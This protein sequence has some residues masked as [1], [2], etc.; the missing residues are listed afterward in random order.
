M[1]VKFVGNEYQVFNKE[2][3]SDIQ[4]KIILFLGDKNSRTIIGFKKISRIEKL[5]VVKS[6]LIY[7]YDYTKEQLFTAIVSL[8]LM[9]LLVLGDDVGDMRYAPMI[10]HKHDNY[11]Q[12]VGAIIYAIVLSERFIFNK[13]LLKEEFREFKNI[14]WEHNLEKD[15]R[16]QL[17]YDH[18]INK[19]F[20]KEKVF[21]LKHIQLTERVK[22]ISGVEVY[23]D[24]DRNRALEEIKDSIDQNN[25]IID[26]I[27][28]SVE[29]NNKIADEIERIKNDV[30]RNL[31]RN[32]EIIT[33]FVAVITLII[34]NVSFLPQISENSLLG[35]VSLVLIINGALVTGVSTLVLV[36]ARVLNIEPEKKSE[37]G[38]ADKKP[39]W[40]KALIFVCA[41]L[42]L[43][44]IALS[45]VDTFCGKDE[46]GNQ[47]TEESNT[48]NDTI[49][50][51]PQNVESSSPAEVSDSVD[52][53]E[54]EL[55]KELEVT[56]IAE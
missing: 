13:Q 39:R 31:L 53:V 45:V 44:G 5:A 14:D 15:L 32:I 50:V 11:V 19:Y 17:S 4:K 22:G 27:Q 47:V 40:K 49:L 41:G 23:I 34:G 46:R 35:A 20:D 8:C 54:E 37:Q 28:T 30:Q 42:L 12:Y 6:E 33:I 38:Q 7:E 24:L 3:L 36:L 16:N 51:M 29:Q 48:N 55:E 43:V 56:E 26:K 2:T 52:V 1:E 18:I 9:D 10:Q 21:K 25:Q